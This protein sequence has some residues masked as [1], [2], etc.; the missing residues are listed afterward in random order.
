MSSFDEYY[1]QWKK[2]NKKE[3]K[4]YLPTSAEEISK[5]ANSYI[6]NVIMP[7]ITTTSSLKKINGNKYEKKENE[8]ILNMI[9]K[10][11]ENGW[12]SMQ[13]GF[14]SAGQTIG[15]AIINTQADRVNLWNEQDK[16]MLQN[17]MEK[18]PEEKN[19]LEK[20]IKNPLL[21]SEKIKKEG[22]EATKKI[23]MEKRKNQEKIQKNVEGINNPVGKYIAGDIVPAIGQMLPGIV[24][25]GMG[26]TY[27]ISS[28]TGNYYD[29]AKQRGMSEDQA[30][31]YS[32]TMGI[33]E[34]SLE[35][36]GS[37]LT[38]NV[39][40]Q[41]LKKNIKGALVNYGL[42]IGEN[43]LEE[44]IVEPVSELV[45]ETTAG[46]DKA[47][48]ENIE[49]RFLKSG[50][51]GAVT[52]MITGGVSGIIGGAGSKIRQNKYDNVNKGNILNENL[53]KKTENVDSEN[54]NT[55]LPFNYNTNQNNL[56]TQQ[57]TQPQNK[58]AP[59]SNIIENSTKIKGYHGTDENFDNFDLKYFG[60]HDQGDF[61]KAVYFSDNE[62][63]ALKYGKNV[64]QQDIE[65]NNPYIIN[66]EEDYKQLWSQ[67]V[68]E[69]DVSKLDKTELKLLKDPY[70]SQE[71]K[72][73][74][75]YDKLN[76][77]EKANA[78]QKLGYDGVI[79]NIYGQI[80][81]FNID[82]INNIANNQEKL[83]NSINESESGINGE[84]QREGMAG[85][86]EQY[87]TR[88]QQEG[89]SKQNYTKSEYE[90]WEQSIKPNDYITN[91][92]KQ[93]KDNI[94]TKYGKDIVFFNESNGNYNAGT[95]LKNNDT[96]Y[97]NPSECE[98]FGIQRTVLHEV[99]ESNIA[100]YREVSNDII[101]PAIQKI[102]EDPNFEKQKQEFWK[103]QLG[104]I[105]SDYAIA[106]DILCD[107]F[108]EMETGEKLDYNNVLS[109]QTNMTIDYSVENFNQEL[110]KSSSI[111][112][113][114]NQTIQEEIRPTRHE[115]I[116]NNREIARENIKNISTWKDKKSGIKYQLET[117]E[118]NMY[119]IIP[120]KAEAKRINDTYFEPIHTS[121]AEKQKFINNYNDK[122]KQYDLN[123]YES[124]AVQFLGEKKYNPDFYKGS[125]ED[126]SIRDEIR[127]KISEN[128]E[129]GKIDREKVNNAIEEFRTIYD[130]L[131]ELE[132]KTLR[133]NGYKEKPY[134]K[135][136]FPHFVDYTPQTR[137]EK[138]LDKLGFKIDRRSLP[139]D[140]AGITEQFVPGKTWN[141]S[142]LERKTNKTNYNALKGF[143]T[144]I[145]QAADNIFHTEDIQRLRGLENE[146]RYQY[147][148]KGIKE[149]INN[150][151]NDE[152]LFEEEKQVLLDGIL[153]QA[154][155]PMPNLVTELR[156]YTNALANKKSE[157]DRSIEQSAG[158]NIYST[159]N[160]IENRFGA[161]A[162]GLNIGSAITNF[163]PITQAY[164]QVSTKNMGRAIIDT[165]KSYANND[166]FVDKSA[167]LTSRLN[168][169]EKLYKT[170]LEKISDKTSFLFNAIDE[171]T[172]NI[173][174]RGKYLENIQNGM[175]EVEAI[176]NA[177]QFA[178][179][180]IADRSKGALPTKFE[181]K[182]PVTKMFTQF[183]LEVNNQYR[184]MFKDI[185]RDL[186]EKGLG[187]I[188][189]AFFKMFVGAWIYNEASE[190]IT[191]RKPAFSPIDLVLSSYRTIT[192]KDM[193]TYDK[194]TS[195]GTDITEQLP[196]I[197]SLVGGGRVPVNGAIPNVGNLTKAGIGLATREMD[198]NRAMD[199]IGK[200]LS[201]PLYYLLPPFGGGQVKKSVEGIRA[202]SKGG[203]YGIDSKGEET[204][205]FPVEN[206]N[207]GDYIKAG[208]F[209][210]YALPKAKEYVDEG[211]KS[212]NAKDTKLYKNSKINY[213][214]L[215]KYIE[216][217]DEKA[218][219]KSK[220]KE[221]KTKIIKNL[222]VSTDQK[223]EIYKSDIFSTTK[224]KNGTTEKEDYE[225]LLKQG[226]S[227]GTLIQ[228]Y[229]VNKIESKKDIEGKTIE[230]SSQG[231]KALAI[232]QMN[233]SDNQK[234]KM[235]SLITTGKNP[236]TVSTLS[237]LD[238]TE[239]AYTNYFALNR[240]DTF[241]Q[242]N[243]SRD[244]M[245]D[246][247]E[248]GINQ[249][250][251]MKFAQNIGN[252]KSEKDKNGKTIAGSK[253][254]AVANYIN[255]LNL[256]TEEKAILF[257]KAGYPDK[258]YKQD[259]YNYIN[260]LNLS[261]T[262]KKE[263]WNS[264]G[265]K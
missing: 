171:V 55:N 155:N 89:Q 196:F 219:N 18:N 229:D 87:G 19:K 124:E 30:N 14:K 66:T 162:V 109:Q 108:A 74:M 244:D 80:A 194:L 208:V 177:D 17:R 189:L 142:T 94:K 211:F 58:N 187:A 252:I 3:E 245:Q 115:I 16:K 159:V 147:S 235:L 224:K 24:G 149:R 237:R 263:I 214:I 231:Q 193:K 131:F 97:I 210:K 52:S 22:E 92:Q 123:K 10:T 212:L 126:I 132:N 228:W 164:S 88:I 185:P 253:K 265:Y 175:S 20:A 213:D 43:F 45:A 56:E 37:K 13:N 148:D 100:S 48:W 41:L 250:E 59:D 160:A 176:K 77:E 35:T 227:K 139:T 180:V 262:R 40:K 220:S 62:N 15:R 240:S 118:R 254:K 7:K 150:I 33:I 78:I 86:S 184:Y 47:N 216:S 114:K 140:I 209:G 169:S 84:I 73:F 259:I 153:E 168:Q 246:I 111:N 157:A 85:I 152:T 218:N 83:Y 239:R 255:S 203:S 137:T 221:D 68:K 143:D 60:K 23:D 101:Q 130:E 75:L 29:D 144:Y 70:T 230:G 25:G 31:I 116:Q 233:V 141:K 46:K 53:M 61:G 207:V 260:G 27:F 105:P 50:I 248:L 156:R 215:K 42:D 128:I 90:Q 183:Q 119:D 91:E 57:I 158:R 138:V 21:S 170:S 234:N 120:D 135:G 241:F 26:S 102:I 127:K 236:E 146:I 165:V 72:N 202:V 81:V 129:N 76:S 226:F 12:L 71:E 258:S 82:K 195:I 264:L 125:Q 38:T 261:A 145:S 163:I 154:D 247:Q 179:N 65:L 9:G 201:K 206:A 192:D 64:K 49:Q 205:Q 136:Y 225:N 93:I 151:L 199:T 96:I 217:R 63:T 4:P 1:N 67:L 36:L 191:G 121:E 190:K 222:P 200:E 32:G 249:D 113:P 28:A 11:V 2:N 174:V 232:M 44:A 5:S 98:A 198:S 34:G 257:A 134:R 99:I 106:K 172:S 161:N 181:E 112:L 39:G 104:E 110:E 54:Q 95:S 251:F 167:F 107:R 8:N 166:G 197:G 6:D 223:W 238:K 188:A 117:M 133:E 186:R 243:I 103:D 204:L 182:N 51:D 122:I 69:T 242:V 173:V 178:R 256:S 79:D